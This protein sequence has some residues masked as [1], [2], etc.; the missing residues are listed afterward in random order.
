VRGAAT[1]SSLGD[2]IG[3]F[4]VAKSPSRITLAGRRALVTGAS[5]GLNLLTQAMAAAWGRFNIQA[6]AVAPTVI[7]T[8]MGQQV[9]GDPAKGDPMNARIL[10]RRFGEPVE[11]AYRLHRR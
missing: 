1:R 8:E 10:A 4:T 5:H 9:W 11:V 7:L 6:N 2:Q 3:V